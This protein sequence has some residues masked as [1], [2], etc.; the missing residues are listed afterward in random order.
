[1]KLEKKSAYGGACS[2]LEECENGKN[3]VCSSIMCTCSDPNVYF[4]NGTYCG[5][6]F[7]V[8]K[9]CFKFISKKKDL[10]KKNHD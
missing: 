1:M 10:I 7:F 9:F 8:F 6:Y 3:M 5:K 2:S 4:W